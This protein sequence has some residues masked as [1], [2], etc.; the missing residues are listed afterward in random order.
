[1]ILITGAVLAILIGLTHS[2]LG[3]RYIL[4]RLLRMEQL[5]RLFGDDSFT[6]NTL[7]FAWH[8]TTIA[9]WGFGVML[10]MAA[11]SGEMKHVVLL[12]SGA[13]F[14]L[15]GLLSFVFTRGRHLSWIVFWIV[16]GISFYCGLNN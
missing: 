3:E 5:P 1:M 4:V 6:R 2:I 16:A 7:R 10:W 12:T 9:W 8:L 15:S 13:V 11:G 14:L